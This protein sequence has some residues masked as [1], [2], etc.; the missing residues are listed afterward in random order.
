MKMM[1]MMMISGFPT[2]LYEGEG[3]GAGAGDGGTGGDGAPPPPPPGGE[4]GGEG[5]GGS[6]GEGAK[7]TAKWYEAEGFDEDARRFVALKGLV[8][9]PLEE[10]LPTLLK[11]WRGAETRL[12]KP[13]DSLI[14]RPGKDEKITDWMRKNGELFGVP[15]DAEGY[16]L[17]PGELPKGVK[18]D[19][20]FAAKARALAHEHALPETALGAMAKLYTEQQ[21]AQAQRWAD[22]TKQA[23]EATMAELR[24]DWGPN[25][26]AKTEL[27]K[28]ALAHLGEKAGMDA[29]ALLDATMALEEKSGSANLLRLFAALGDSLGED[30]LIT[31]GG[32]GGIATTPAEAKQRLEEMHAPD[33]PY[34]KA[35][36][37]NDRKTVERFNAERAR[38]FKVASGSR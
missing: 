19:E 8:D 24:K 23:S 27:A 33:H 31:G 21:A 12:G 3:A 16:K 2:P 29:D 7:P 37:S 38:L 13:A 18:W 28:R 15:K 34:Q 14:D 35:L 22:E 4:G 26:P 1:R 5:S 25:L 36:A 30:T 9:K 11:G 6:G 32:D 10:A 17:E 20:D